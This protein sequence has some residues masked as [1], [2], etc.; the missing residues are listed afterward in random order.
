MLGRDG[1]AVAL[2]IVSAKPAGHFTHGP[3]G[4]F[5]GLIRKAQK[6]ELYLEKTLWVLRAAKRGKAPSRALNCRPA[7]FPLAFAD[8]NNVIAFHRRRVF[9]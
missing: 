3:A 1:A 9:D 6:G 2:A 7:T 5:G 4:Y 8:G